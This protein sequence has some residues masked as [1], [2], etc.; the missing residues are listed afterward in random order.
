M[1][2]KRRRNF[3]RVVWPRLVG[4]RDRSS[5]S[6][7][8]LPRIIVFP[9][10]RLP[11]AIKT[12]ADGRPATRRGEVGI[13]VLGIHAE[14]RQ[15]GA[16]VRAAEAQQRRPRHPQGGRTA[17]PP[18]RPKPRKDATAKATSDL[19]E[20]E[21][22]RA[23]EA[24]TAEAIARSLRDVVPAED[25]MPLDAALEWSRQDW[26]REEAEQ[27]RRLLDLAAAQRRAAAAQPSRGAPV[28]KLEES[29]DDDLYRPTPPRFGDAGQGSSRQT[30]PPQDGGD[31][32]D[33]GGDYTAFCRRL[34][35]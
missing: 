13:T 35:M 30:P 32:S 11:R 21:A 12:A 31:S 24:A 10:H 14:D 4:E 25:A 6:S 15:A 20:A 8:R 16:A 27:Q 2:V 1:R 33:D 7:S 26:E 9:A 18:C 29:S 22:A 17:S 23:E 3:P 5:S 19:A 28:I 34:G